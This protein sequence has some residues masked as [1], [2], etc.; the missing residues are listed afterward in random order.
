MSACM[1]TLQ[2]VATN[3]NPPPPRSATLSPANDGPIIYRVVLIIYY[4]LH[5]LHT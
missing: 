4:E 2:R 5:S 1:Q 3:I